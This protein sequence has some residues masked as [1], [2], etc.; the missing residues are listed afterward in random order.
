M[1]LARAALVLAVLLAVAMP[2]VAA[3]EVTIAGWARYGFHIPVN[4][5]DSTLHAVYA[6]AY[7][8]YKADDFNTFT[9]QMFNNDPVIVASLTPTAT[10]TI[11]DNVYIYYAYLTTNLAKYLKIDGSGLGIS[12]INGKL[13]HGDAG[14]GNVTQSG[15]ED[16]SAAGLGAAWAT[17]GTITYKTVGGFEYAVNPIGNNDFYFGLYTSQTAN[18]G[19]ISA[20]IAYDG[21]SGATFGDGI[22]VT[23]G[24]FQRTFG[25]ITAKIGTGMNYNIASAALAWNAGLRVTHKTLGLLSMA[26]KGV[27]GTM[28]NLFIA[29][30]AVNAVP[31]MAFLGTVKL[32]FT[33]GV[34]LFN[35]LDAAVRFDVGVADFFLGY[36][37]GQSA[38]WAPVAFTTT[39]TDRAAHSGP[40]FKVDI[41]Y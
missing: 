34:D 30:F 5:A 19:T 16:T 29:D 24:S 39:A 12:L 31:N 6:R 36:Q 23:D 41:A 14:Y 4:T 13:W 21:N 33:A 25:D 11:A 17:A 9:L 18:F 28:L 1:R 8:T 10:T 2:A 35:T 26:V 3:S 22:V 27:T 38:L 15:W 7:L 37:L 40:Y 20:E 32:D